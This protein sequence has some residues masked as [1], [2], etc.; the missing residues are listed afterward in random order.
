R[1]GA[2]GVG[3]LVILRRGIRA[4]RAHDE[5]G[6][7]A[8]A[9]GRDP[10]MLELGIGEVAEHGRLRCLLHRPGVVRALPT[11]RL[12]W[13]TC[14]AHR[15]PD[16]TRRL[17]RERGG[18]YAD[19]RQGARHGHDPDQSRLHPAEPVGPRPGEGAF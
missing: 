16:I 15:T 5:F 12:G 17:I 10:E 9:A 18:W 1:T 4:A 6:A 19:Q 11:F 3:D 14:R 2:E 8:E 13:M 7:A